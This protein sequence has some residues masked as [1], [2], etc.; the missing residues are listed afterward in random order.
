MAFS[1]DAI[2][3]Y[4]QAE[5]QLT[6][7][8]GDAVDAY[9]KFVRDLE[10]LNKAAY[11][12]ASQG[13]GSLSNLVEA[14]ETLP[15]K[16][17]TSYKEALTALRSRIKPVTQPI[18]VVFSPKSKRDIAQAIGQAISRALSG[19]KIR[20]SAAFPAKPLGL[21]DTTNLRGKYGSIAQPPDMK[22]KLEPKKFKK[23]GIVEG[24]TPGKDSVLSLLEPG[25]LVVPKD[26]VKE[27]GKLRGEAGQFISAKTYA[28]SIARI[29]NLGKGLEKLKVAIDAGLNDGKAL[30]MFE[31]GM[32]ELDDEIETL[33]KNSGNLSYQTQVR[34]APAIKDVRLKMEQL[35]GEADKTGKVT[36][37]LLAKILGPAKFLAISTALE[38]VRDGFRELRDGGRETYDVLT[39]GTIEGFTTNLNQANQVLGLS[40]DKLRDLKGEAFKAATAIDGI[41]PQEFSE[42]LEDAAHAGART[43]ARLN[44]IAGASAAAA[45]GFGLARDDA[46]KMN[47]ELTD[48]LK[49][50][51]Q[52]SEGLLATVGK[53]SS[54]LNVSAPVLFSQMQDDV[55]ALA[56]SLSKMNK[57]DGEQTI[58]SF[59]RMGAALMD[60]GVS[61][62]EV[63]TIRQ[64]L[65]KAFEGG[66]ENV[67]AMSKAQLLTGQSLDV[68]RAKLQ[69]GDIAGLFQDIQRQA[70]S[71]DPGSL[72]TFATQA[73]I[74][75]NSLSKMNAAG[76]GLTKTMEGTRSTVVAAGDGMAY[77]TERAKSN[78]TVFKNLMETVSETVGGWSAFGIS[79][80]DVVDTLAE[81]NFA[82]VASI[83][84]LGK[85]GAQ[86]AWATAKFVAMGASM[87][88][89][90]F[91]D[92]LGIGSKVAEA[93]SAASTA[94][95]A[96][97]S[98][99]AGG[100]LFAGLSAGLTALAGGVAALGA[101]LLS[102]PGIAF[103]VS[104]VV[105]LLALGAALNLA[106]PAIRVFGDVAIAAIGKAVEAFG[107]LVPVL[108]EIVKV[109]GTVLLAAIDGIVQVF[110]TLFSADAT[111]LLTIGPAL[112][113]V[114]AG[115]GA[116]AT[117]SAALAAVQIGQ[118]ILSFLTGGPADV[119]SGVFG[120]LA[121]MIGSVRNLKVATPEAVAALTATVNGLGG[122]AL[123]YARLTNTLGEMPSDADLGPRMQQLAGN[124]A[125]ATTA[126]NLQQARTTNAIAPS[127][128]QA[129]VDAI[130]HNPATDAIAA[131]ATRTN[132]LLAQILQVLAQGQTQQAV[133]A[134][135]QRVQGGPSLAS[136]SPLTRDV[137][138]F[139]H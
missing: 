104:L 100:G 29:D 92:M 81:V 5:D 71:L 123:A 69:S 127:Q 61:A 2:G 117:A 75:S 128:L 16:A 77:L 22:G 25:E 84:Y 132:E 64:M 133:N 44:A 107:M 95:S 11:K 111:Q 53:L 67:D 97:G 20:L 106:S 79:G 28:E 8:L 9:R 136:S 102:P 109:A 50:S 43:T 31:R 52:Q 113:S 7:T 42:G 126:S 91:K 62:D 87:A 86:A 27:I 15:E 116:V 121:S 17:I 63:G 103:T 26:L 19:V 96:A 118:G 101:V 34:L 85:M 90:K 24:G 134:P 114:A 80:Q 38:H 94:A 30:K 23:G 57:T 55:T 124:L 68:L 122:F 56:S 35:R 32:K 82:S 14:F 1:A 93:A 73:G 54:S 21:F 98:A 58:N 6:P 78:N 125:Q 40:R 137:A 3:F 12:S 129:V 138:A 88:A 18:N 10:K 112:F 70:S 45:K 13:I 66:A 48:N 49:F 74:S 139:G 83:A 115:L 120:L 135:P 46:A 65:A 39:G 130:M 37:N 4:L 108:T 110:K 51:Q 41:N 33:V 131:S 76:Q 105:A 72:A 60:S 99:A 47:Y 36:N 119:G 59:N 89:A